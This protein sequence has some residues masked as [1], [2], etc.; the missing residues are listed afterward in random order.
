M[1]NSV[2]IVSGDGGTWVS[3]EKMVVVCNVE[4]CH[5]KSLL[6]STDMIENCFVVGSINQEQAAEGSSGVLPAAL[7]PVSAFQLLCPQPLDCHGL[8]E[9]PGFELHINRLALSH[10]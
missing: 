4:T 1:E 5:C 7:A 3:V 8:E 2:Q 10:L 9:Q 6:S